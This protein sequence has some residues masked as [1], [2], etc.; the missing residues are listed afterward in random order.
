MAHGA[1]GREARGDVTT[2]D[3]EERAIEGCDEC[4]EGGERLAFGRENAEAVAEDVDGDGND[5]HGD[6]AEKNR[7][8]TAKPS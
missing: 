1:I 7:A 5:D 6:E 2:E 8:D 4:S 3:S